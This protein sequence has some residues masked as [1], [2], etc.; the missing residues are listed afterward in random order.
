MRHH[1]SRRFVAMHLT[2]HVHS[3]RSD[4]FK[5]KWPQHKI[6]GR[7]FEFFFFIF[8]FFGGGFPPRPICTLFCP[9]CRRDGAKKGP[10]TSKNDP[11][12]P[13]RSPK[14][15]L[16]G[17][18]WLLWGPFWSTFGPSG[19]ILGLIL[20]LYGVPDGP[21]GPQSAPKRPMWVHLGPFWSLF[22]PF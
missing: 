4:T 20:R 3:S 12:G 7:R 17:P 15:L 10:K 13:Q 11:K 9:K 14:G 5:A 19:L 2:S 16:F 22:G 6:Q 18:F 21:N 1:T 8:F